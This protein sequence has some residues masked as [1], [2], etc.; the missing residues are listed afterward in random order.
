MS[1]QDRGPHSDGASGG[2]H[3]DDEGAD[4]HD[5]HC[6]GEGGPASVTVGPATEEP[7]SERPHDEGRP[8]NRVD[9]D[10]L[11]RVVRREELVLEIG[12]ERRVRVHV[13]LLDEV[14]HRPLDG[15][16]YCAV[17][18]RFAAY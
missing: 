9:V 3:G 11:V 12:C 17:H 10:A 5:C 6:H 14:A 15:V 18:V 13:E 16:P 8:E 4:G 2:Q 7:R 1:K